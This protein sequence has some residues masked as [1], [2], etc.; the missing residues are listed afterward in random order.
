MMDEADVVSDLDQLRSRYEVLRTLGYDGHF[1]VY[2][3]RGRESN[4]HYAVKVI[5][6]PGSRSTKPGALQM[7][8]AHTVKP[9][10]HP[11]V[12][13]LH[14]VHHLQGGGVA[15]AMD[16]R[17][18]QTLA[19]LIESAGPLSVA[20]AEAV[21]RE[22]ALALAYLHDRG[23][24]HR[25]VSPYSIFLDRDAGHA[26]LAPFGVERTGEVDD[27]GA[28]T[29]TASP[30]PLLQALAFLAPEQIQGQT[31]VEG[32]GLSPRS[33]LYSL[34]LVGY[35]M[36]SGA[37]PWKTSSLADLVDKR[38]NGPRP[39]PS[40]VRA[41]LPGYLCRA[42]E[43]CL[44][45]SPRRRWRNVHEFL[46]SL[47]SSVESPLPRPGPGWAGLRG[48][49]G[50]RLAALGR[51]LR[52]RP[53]LVRGNFAWVFTAAVA[54]LVTIA[55]ASGERATIGDRLGDAQWVGKTAQENA[56][57]RSMRTASSPGTTQAQGRAPSLAALS[58]GSALL[59]AA[60]GV[61]PSS[62]ELPLVA[63][64]STR[65]TV[66]RVAAPSTDLSRGTPPSRPTP[67]EPAAEASPL[68]GLV[69]LGDPIA[70]DSPR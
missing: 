1:V 66:S 41:D 19:E 70:S 34:G 52:K 11:K 7:W 6:D 55:V 58:A 9:L 25:G 2:A 64:P 67:A 44:E 18:G 53:R 38:A 28:S 68:G 36:L 30:G 26:R 48:R 16:R 45:E 14:A 21:L 59:P 12:M 33:D 24:V 49:V 57:S 56:S 5:G 10:D 31:Q 63:P 40:T 62:R 50:D 8:Q 3:V 39:A 32:R 42:I 17:R 51:G 20:T 47:E 65:N 37:S 60:V 61:E 43:G 46:A 4:R 22:I 13:V 54:G 15:L 35:A 69:L 27:A 29:V 23:V